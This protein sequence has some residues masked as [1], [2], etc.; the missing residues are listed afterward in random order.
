MGM[1]QNI[2]VRPLK[3]KELL[4]VNGGSDCPLD[5]NETTH[6]IGYAIGLVVG[7]LVAG[8]LVGAKRFFEK[9]LF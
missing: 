1:I 6:T 2:N 9:L 7:T 8:T 3:S 4:E 5:Q